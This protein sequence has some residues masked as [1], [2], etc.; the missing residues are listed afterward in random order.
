M[1]ILKLKDIYIND[2]ISIFYTVKLQT[3]QL[4]VFDRLNWAKNENITIKARFCLAN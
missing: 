2:R 3:S 4:S 1:F